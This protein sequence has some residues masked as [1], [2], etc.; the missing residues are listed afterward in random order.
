MLK[1]IL[2]YVGVLIISGSL[3]SACATKTAY[4]QD[5]GKLVSSGKYSD[6]VTLT[7]QS[8]DS[9]YG[10]KNA[11]LYCLDL[12]MLL[13]LSGNYKE[14]NAAF[15]NAKRLFDELFTKSVTTEASTFLISDN[16][17]PYYGED[18]ERAHV[19]IFCALNYLMLGERNEALVEA[20]QADDFLKKL[21]T[22]YGYKNVYKEDAFA[23][24]LMGM[25]YED[26]G[27]V[28]DALI[29]YKIAL[30]AYKD[31]QKV[32]K[33]TAPQELVNDALRAASKLRFDNDVQ[34]IKNDWQVPSYE[35]LPKNFGELVLIDY[36]GFSAEKIDSFF[37][38]SFGKAWIY[39]NGMDAR[40]KEREEV[41]QAGA[42]ARSIIMDEQIR[43]AFP[44]YEK[45]PSRIQGFRVST[46][47]LSG[48]SSEGEVVQ[49]ISAIAQKNLEDRIS[50]IKI[51]TIARAAVKF[52]RAHKI[53][54]K[55]AKDS[56]DKLLGWITKKVLNVASAAT[57]HADKR[58][59]RSLPDKILIARL[60]L[61]EG[62]YSIN[63]KFYDKSGLPIEQK[64]LENIEIK[65]R[66]KTFVIVRSAD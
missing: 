57:E 13:H 23:R 18:F 58:S 3:I 66:K 15:E 65:S 6:A 39:V 49:D 26:Q 5:V 12:G 36:N 4:Y 55:V 52:A 47:D 14:S 35:E 41:E 27:Q 63:L 17:R 40:G 34:N 8:K 44:K 20:R 31:Y 9:A 56:N 33:L 42:I 53:S 2:R 61:N 22:D 43:M 48:R 24:Y 29:S 46:Q 16:M 54:E 50:R 7:E 32:Y 28:N 30:N 19:N 62:K 59:W 37:E 64:T 25:I 51:K 10:N 45:I 11:L 1:R 38:I 21:Q 60:P